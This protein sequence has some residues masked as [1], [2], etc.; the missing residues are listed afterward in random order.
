MR[1]WGDPPIFPAPAA[2]VKQPHPVIAQSIAP[3]Y[4]YPARVSARPKAQGRLHAM[5]RLFTALLLAS[6]LLPRLA[7]AQPA[8]TCPVPPD[9]TWTTSEAWIWSQIC[10]GQVADLTT[11]DPA[12]LSM[13]SDTPWPADRT[14]SASFLSELLT[15]PSYDLKLSLGPMIISGMRVADPVLISSA[16]LHNGLIIH[17]SR[18]DGGLEM[19][20]SS[21]SKGLYLINDRFGGPLV[22]RRASLAWFKLNSS[23]GQSLIIDN[24]TFADSVFLDAAAISGPFNINDSSIGLGGLVLDSANGTY[25]NFASIALIGTKINGPV[26]ISNSHLSG[27]LHSALM[28]FS[29][30][31]TVDDS[32]FAG[33][34]F[35]RDSDFAR[36]VD[37]WSTSFANDLRFDTTKFDSEFSV[38]NVTLC[39]NGK[40]CEIFLPSAN[41]GGQV[42]IENTLINGDINTD[43]ATAADSI[44]LMND[45]NPQHPLALKMMDTTI[46]RDLTIGSTTL[47]YLF[48]PNAN[49]AGT[50]QFLPQSNGI[51]Q[52]NAW[53]GMEGANIGVLQN[54]T[55]DWPAQMNLEGM[56]FGLIGLKRPDLDQG[57]INGKWSLWLRGTNY[58]PEPYEQVAKYL[59]DTGDASAA[60]CVLETS[61]TRALTQMRPL[62]KIVYW[63]YGQVAGFGYAPL[64]C[65][66]CSFCA[67]PAKAR[68]TT[69]QSACSTA[70]PNSS[71][72]SAWTINS[73]ISN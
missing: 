47:A 51:W 31:L 3:A 5:K 4:R 11:L 64:F 14:I 23:F 10:T 15:N 22:L 7:H 71:R 39:L 34:A 50:L 48:L 1:A 66:A 49:I 29:G 58:S 68:S 36:G 54:A 60:T 27:E 72:W 33:A 57:C 70:S 8:P 43:G 63:T 20:D 2:Q 69:C 32:T 45:G 12:R 9:P 25:N 24:S 46:S 38:D 16:N 13:T 18:F 26:T 44:Q 19:V 67:Q 62:Q 37:V 73:A 59:S 41:F 55:W 28:T 6:I 30:G 35:F 56:R 53:L 61:Q 65:S 42:L 52:K 21:S 40:P 17:A